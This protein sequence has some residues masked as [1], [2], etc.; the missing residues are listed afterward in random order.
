MTTQGSTARAWAVGG[1]IFAAAMMVMLGIWQIFVGIAAIAEGNFFVVAPNYTYEIDT[2]AWG[3]IH[4]ILGVIATV[5]GF[6]LF[7]GAVW[8]RAIG[9]ALAVLSAIANFFFLPYYPLW[10]I[11]IIAAN[12]FVIWA[13][14][15]AGT[16]RPVD[17]LVASEMAGYGE[18][19]SQAH[20]NGRPASS[21]PA[22][23]QAGD[24]T[25]GAAGAGTRGDQAGQQ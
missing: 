20:G 10:S 6:F 16:G 13:L 4:L 22:S 14:A 5:T 18:N 7:T 21:Q 12:V 8:A 11:M 15:T 25:S 2:T 23:P 17:E 24:Q 19:R 3:W 1:M 9:I